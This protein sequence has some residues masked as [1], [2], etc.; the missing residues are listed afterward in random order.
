ME[1][2]NILKGELIVSCQALEAEPLY[3][4]EIMAK[5]AT[6]AIEGGAK[7]IRANSLRDIQAIQRAV[8]VPVIGIIKKIYEDSEVYIT[9]TVKEVDALVSQGVTVVAMDATGRIRPGGISLEAFFSEIRARY[10]RQ[11]FMADV[12]NVEEARAARDLGFDLIATTLV[13]YTPYTEGENPLTVLEGIVQT[14]DAPIIAEGNIETPAMAARALE[15]GAYSV[16]VGS[17]I[18]RPQIITKRFV[19]QLHIHKE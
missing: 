9:P 3:G 8:D 5:M 1:R 16:V 17:A 4:S 11:L 13:G 19:N 18:T 2:L 12:S 10:P 14:L 15:L 7:G 6:A